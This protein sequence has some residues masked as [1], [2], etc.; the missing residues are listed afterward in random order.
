MEGFAPH[1][2]RRTFITA[3]LDAGVDL[4]VMSPLAGHTSVKSAKL[5]DWRR[6]QAKMRV[7]ER[8]GL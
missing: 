4:H 7:V 6:K 8:L 2:L 5:Y 3:L 1:D